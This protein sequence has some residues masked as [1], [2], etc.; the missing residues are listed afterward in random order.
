MTQ[1]NRPVPEDF[2]QD[3]KAREELAERMIAI[4]GKLYRQNSVT[5]YIYGRTLVNRSVIDI[6]KAHSFVRKQERNELS[7]FETI[8]VF[9][10]LADLNLGHAHIDVGRITTQFL[11]DNRGLS[12]TDFVK[13]EVGEA[14]GNPSRPLEQ[15]QDVVLYGFGRIG[16]L[17]A[18]LMIEKTAGGDALRLRAV[19]VRKGKAKNDL[20]KRASLFERD[21]VHGAFNGTIR[22]LEDENKLVING[23]EIQFIYSNSPA[24]VDYTEYGIDNAII[25]DNT[26]VW[27]TEKD[28]GQHLQSKG[29]AKVLLTAPGSDIKNIVMGVNDKDIAENDN[30]ICARLMYH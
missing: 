2:F 16:R 6:M 7:E 17:M 29:A 25:V 8:Q 26:G 23:N 19:V 27:K 1:S 22:V 24:E 30:I 11:N 18:R 4:I 13:E 20:E 3:W 12:I 9:E 5:C 14:A 15:P 10:A 28:L 21:S